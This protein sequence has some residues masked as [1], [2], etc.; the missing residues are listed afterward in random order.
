MSQNLLSVDEL[1]KLIGFSKSWIYKK[2]VS[3][4]SASDLPKFIRIGKRI[5]FPKSEIEKWLSEKN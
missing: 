2:V 5:R 1:S 3:L 4:N